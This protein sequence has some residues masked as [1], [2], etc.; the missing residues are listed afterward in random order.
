MTTWISHRG[1]CGEGEVENTL[2]AFK[3]AVRYGFMHLETDLRLSADK[4]LILVHDPH[5]KRLGG[6]KTPVYK[7]KSEQLKQVHLMGKSRILFFDD[8]IENFQNCVWTL[9]IKPEEGFET[10][11]YLAMFIQKSK[12]KTHFIEK[13]KY[14]FWNEAQQ[15]LFAKLVPGVKFYAREKQ[16]WRAGLAILL[17][18]P[19]L[20]GISKDLVYA[21]PPTLFH[22]NLFQEKY[23]K[24]YKQ[25]GA[26]IAA[27]LPENQTQAQKALE[28][29]FDEILT[30]GLI[31]SHK[32]NTSL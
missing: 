32:K 3:Q 14:L 24:A 12:I 20:S 9:D 16:C 22:L 10:V 30:N 2:G 6:S 21:V 1:Y 29:G 11:K 18:L 5:L 31:V 8:F 23:L 25:A 19:S 13:T 26:K 4:K 7:S 15:N 28:L 17:G 27:F